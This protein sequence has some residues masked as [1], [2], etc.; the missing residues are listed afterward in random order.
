MTAVS[1]KSAREIRL[2]REAGAVVAEVHG[3]MRSAV[4]PGVTTR[5]LD[6]QARALIEQ[7]GGQPSFLGYGGFPASICASVNDEVLHGIPGRRVLREGD[8]ISIDVGVFLNGYHADAALTLAVG[9][10]SA[11]ACSLIEATERAFWAGFEA[12]QADQRLGD[13]G[14]AIE[15]SVARDGLSLIAGYT[16]HGIGREMHEAPNV[17]N[18]GPPGSGQRLRPGMTLAVEPM[19]TIGSGETRTLDDDWT[20]VTADGALAAHFEHTVLITAAGPELITAS[21]GRVI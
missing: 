15:Q 6:R 1:L 7:H 20:V 9:Q 8:I 10:V 11:D 4:R 2:M 16:G 3:L 19:V 12:A 21:S 17:A 13:L 14:F 5:D 18:A